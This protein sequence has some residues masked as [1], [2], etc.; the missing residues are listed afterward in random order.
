MDRGLRERLAAARESTRQQEKA[1]R[2]TCNVLVLGDVH[3]GEY[4]KEHARIDYLKRTAEM[5][6]DFCDFLEYYATHR[7][8]GRPWRLISLGDFLDFVTV[9]VTPSAD[10]QEADP[11]LRLG[12]EERKYGL[13]SDEKKVVWKLGRIVDR[14]RMAFTFL[15]DFVGKGNY[16]DM[17]Y[18]NHDIEFFW[19]RAKEAFNEALVDVYFG[20]ER[21]PGK[22]EEW[23]TQRIRWHEWFLYEP[24]RFFIDH[25]NQ[26][27]D[28]SSFEYRLC[29]VLPYRSNDLAIPTSHMAIHFFVNQIE[30]FRTHN[31]DNWTVVDFMR[32][33][34]GQ[35]WSKI[36][37]LLRSYAQL[38]RRLI[39]YSKEIQQAEDFEVRAT[40]EKRM[41]ELARKYGLD[42]ELVK[43]IDDLPNPPV[44]RST[45]GAIQA[46]AVDVWAFGALYFLLVVAALFLP[47]WVAK[48]LALTFLVGLF[49]VRDK[50]FR[51]ARNVF[52]GGEILGMV[53]PK[54]DAAAASLA[55]LL[56]VRY[57]I[58]GHTHKPLVRQVRSEPDCWYLNT[59]SWLVP[60]AK[61]RHRGGCRSPLTYVQ[62]TL[63]E[64]LSHDLL[65]WCQREHK[66]EPFLPQLPAAAEAPAPTGLKVREPPSPSHAPKKGKTAKKADT[67]QRPSLRKRRY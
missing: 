1:E 62:L 56:D 29:P 59:G 46:A 65:R 22:S 51:L 67:P 28:F 20:T 2:E 55:K 45:G 58:M 35:G 32:W 21:I 52:L 26:F 24:E 30:G 31:K 37:F 23:F 6:R 34:Y 19:P 61:E 47:G 25:G 4:I 11:E 42:L 38:S 41:E 50:V 15:A 36:T 27:D 63:G 9:T 8:D 43:K 54:L 40:H 18:G 57:V 49:F 33:V 3:L 14:H 60:S 66:P 53:E 64:T 7:K 48:I 13:D 17:L 12:E 44:H 16:L 5:D 10:A 39:R